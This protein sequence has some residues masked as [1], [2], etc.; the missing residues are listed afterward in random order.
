MLLVT[1]VLGFSSEIMQEEDGIFHVSAE[2][3]VKQLDN[4]HPGRRFHVSFA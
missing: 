3:E 2:T 4:F 1:L